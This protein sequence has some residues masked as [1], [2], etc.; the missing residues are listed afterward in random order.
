MVG[1]GGDKVGRVERGSVD[2]AASQSWG[3]TWACLGARSGADCGGE[4]GMWSKE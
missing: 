4:V 1:G 3:E 2:P